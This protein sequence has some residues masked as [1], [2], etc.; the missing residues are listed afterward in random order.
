[1]TGASIFRKQNGFV[2]YYDRI[3]IGGYSFDA[4]IRVQDKRG[5]PQ[6]IHCGRIISMSVECEGELV[7]YFD[8]GRWYLTPETM[9]GDPFAESVEMARDLLIHKWSNPEKVVLDRMDE[10]LKEDI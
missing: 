1:M 7:L 8:D 2:D 6:A 4:A 9:I 10:I 3:V 5:D